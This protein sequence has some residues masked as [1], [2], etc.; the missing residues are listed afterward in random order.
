M[1]PGYY[2]AESRK[3]WYSAE[4]DAPTCNQVNTGSLQ[5]IADAVE[6]MARRYNDLIAERDKFER[7]Y[8]A[9][10]SLRQTW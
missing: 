8:R 2:R 1:A 10:Q 3:E 7:S 9:E 5:R 6:V 4:N